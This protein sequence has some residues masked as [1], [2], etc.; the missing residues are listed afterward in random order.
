MQRFPLNNQSSQNTPFFLKSFLDLGVALVFSTIALTWYLNVCVSLKPGPFVSK[1]V[2]T[3]NIS[4]PVSS[5]RRRRERLKNLKYLG[6]T[7][8]HTT[9]YGKPEK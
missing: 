1:I 8:L 6:G 4:T 2:V 9:R 7:R 3:I 5:Q